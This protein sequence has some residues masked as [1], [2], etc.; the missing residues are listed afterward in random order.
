MKQLFKLKISKLT[1]NQGTFEL[2]GIMIRRRVGNFVSRWRFM[3]ITAATLREDGVALR[4]ERGAEC[5][6]AKTLLFSE[7]AKFATSATALGSRM[8][9]STQMTI[10]WITD[11]KCRMLDNTNNQR[12]LISS[13][14]PFCSQLN[15]VSVLSLLLHQAFRMNF[16]AH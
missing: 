2:T 13:T 8:I 1:Q 4:R 9:R 3:L 16:Q 6:T 15:L 7:R 10:I 5:C 11:D 12:Q 14:A